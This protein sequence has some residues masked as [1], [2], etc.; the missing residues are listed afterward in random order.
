MGGKAYEKEYIIRIVCN[1]MCV[2]TSFTGCA[3]LQGVGNDESTPNSPKS[4]QGSNKALKEQKAA[5]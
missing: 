2:I 1:N 4:T 3:R 5:S